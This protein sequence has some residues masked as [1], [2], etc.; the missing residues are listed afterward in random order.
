MNSYMFRPVIKM[1]M[2]LF[3]I[4]FSSS[5]NA[6]FEQKGG[7]SLFYGAGSSGLA[8]ADSAFCVMTNPAKVAALGKARMDFLFRNFYQIG[9]LN[10][11]AMNGVFKV[12]GL[13]IGM[14][15]V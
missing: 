14:S 5:V 6:A 10:Q 2:L 7:G 1:A 13:P 9:G 8:S 11:I 15:S 3:V 4:I 12:A